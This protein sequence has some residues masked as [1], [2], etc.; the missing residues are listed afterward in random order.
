M[1][2]LS[3]G[4]SMA[5]AIDALHSCGRWRGWWSGTT[6]SAGSWTA[7]NF[8]GRSSTTQQPIPSLNCVV[9]TSVRYSTTANSSWRCETPQ[10]SIWRSIWRSGD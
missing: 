6:T 4:T 3:A 9:G 1:H 7:G 2:V 10:R 8:R 5:R